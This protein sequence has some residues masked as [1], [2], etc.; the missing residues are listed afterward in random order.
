[1][2]I[3]QKVFQ[4]QLKVLHCQMYQIRFK[5]LYISIKIQYFIFPNTQ[6]TTKSILDQLPGLKKKESGQIPEQLQK[7]GYIITLHNVQLF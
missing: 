6:N 3:H 7:V 2:K 4:I 5:C 1:M